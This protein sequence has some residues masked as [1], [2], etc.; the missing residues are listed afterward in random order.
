MTN[1][2][3]GGAASEGTP[4]PQ[5]RCVRH[6]DR[7]TALSCTRCGRP[8]CP[9]CLRAAS[10][11]H[12]CVDCV[13]AGQREMPQ[14]R[15]V[16][17]AQIRTQNP[18]PVVTYALMALNVLIFAITA[19]Q[20]KSLMDN[21]GGV[22]NRFTGVAT[23]DSPLF[24]RLVLAPDLV[25]QGEWIRLLG[26]GF[27]HFGLVHLAVNM[28]ALWVL[29]RDT[30]FVLGRSRYLAVY[31]LALFGGSASA[32][33][34][35]SL[36]AFTA[37]A[38]GAIFGIMGAQAV[39]LLRMRRSANPILAVIGLN[40]VISLTVPGISLWGHIGGLV[41]GAAATAVLVYA[42]TGQRTAADLA[43]SRTLGW[44]GLAAVGVLVAGLIALR[45]VGLRDQMGLA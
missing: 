45:V 13:A 6:P 17:G 16:S 8:A 36:G 37:G 19:L 41:V 25:A 33:T 22:I 42:P 2:G 9:D 24:G 29:G 28:F 1:P 32:L 35:E 38:S 43:R 39:L 27:L 3:W 26:S 15:T 5:P 30:E 18:T 20:A 23:F 34:F 14:A 40:I 11:G 10:V 44:V 4:P 31:L 7:P 21:G 12:Q